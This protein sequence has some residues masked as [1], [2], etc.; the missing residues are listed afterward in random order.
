MLIGT[1]VWTWTTGEMKPVHAREGVSRA[2]SLHA[3]LTDT[4]G[5]KLDMQVWAS[6]LIHTMRNTGDI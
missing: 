6:G 1:V 2:S 3:P 4:W 5:E